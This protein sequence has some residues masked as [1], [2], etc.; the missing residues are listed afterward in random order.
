MTA[1]HGEEYWKV[2]GIVL[3]S[4]FNININVI[5]SIYLD[6]SFFSPKMEVMV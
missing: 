4:E 2:K 5:F 6:V 3:G 1:V